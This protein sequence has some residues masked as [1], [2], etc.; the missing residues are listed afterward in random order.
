M[1]RKP[2]RWAIGIDLGGSSI[3][4]GLVGEDGRILMF[5]RIPVERLGEAERII[6]ALQHEVER[7]AREAAN[8]GWEPVGVGVA[9]PGSIE[10]AR[11]IIH[12]SPNLPHLEGYP[13]KDHLVRLTR[14]PLHLVNDANAAA[15]GELKFGAGVDYRH[16]ALLTLGTGIG[17]AI[18]VD[19]RLYQGAAGFAG[20]I[21]HMVIDPEGPACPCGNR[22]CL[23]RL[24]GAPALLERA[25]RLVGEARGESALG[26]LGKGALSVEAIAEAAQAGDVV[27]LQVLAEM[28]RWLGLALI[29]LIN[30]LDPDCILVGGGIAQAG[31]P[32]FE[33]IR[34]TVG[35]HPMSGT[36]RVV[37]IVTATLGPRAGAAGAGVLALWPEL[38]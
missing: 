31:P 37:P 34:R 29:S 38:A 17:G 19:G 12:K 25:A 18:V 35:T 7:L 30:L 11:G 32:L 9:S 4:G 28:G 2:V 23:E 14:L 6:A 33:A 1:S 16:F 8:R 22:G 5:N 15:L 20:E 13:L 3:K 21:G 26:R 27:A 24:V 36:A 10:S